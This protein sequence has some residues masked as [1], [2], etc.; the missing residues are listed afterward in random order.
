MMKENIQPMIQ[1]IFALIEEIESYTFHKQTLSES[2]TR[3]QKEYEQGSYT[4]LE[5]KGL[6]NSILKGRSRKEWNEYY[7]AYIY[8][9]YKKIEPFL[10]QIKN[11]IRTV[12]LPEIEVELE[13]EI[14]KIVE[15]TTIPVAA[16]ITAHI[17]APVAAAIYEKTKEKA[18]KKERISE[19]LTAII[20][21]KKEEKI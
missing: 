6:L 3:L 5:Y 12:Q 13:K 15:K 7:D 10:F 20:K 1:P 19:R 14:E 4:Y 9:L 21:E 18:M 16:P 11:R 17:T 8:S 2:F